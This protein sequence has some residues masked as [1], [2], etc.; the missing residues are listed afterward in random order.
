MGYKRRENENMENL[1]TNGRKKFV[2]YDEGAAMFPKRNA[3]GSLHTAR[4]C[5]SP[6]PRSLRRH[7]SFCTRLSHRKAVSSIKR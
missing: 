5:I 6:K 7:L 3:T 1:L 2:K 4:K